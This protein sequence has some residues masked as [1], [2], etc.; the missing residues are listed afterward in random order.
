MTSLTRARPD[1]VILVAQQLVYLTETTAPLAHLLWVC[2]NVVISFALT[3]RQH[4]YGCADLSRDVLQELS[5]RTTTQLT[6]WEKNLTPELQ[7][8]LD[9]ETDIPLPH[10]LMLQYGLVTLL[11]SYTNQAHSAWNTTNFRY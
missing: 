11:S 2:S 8:H 7:V 9:K 1:L 4:R 10:V 3:D 6:A 5:E